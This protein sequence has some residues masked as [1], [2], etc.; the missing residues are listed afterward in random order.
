MNTK[1]ED[2]QDDP[3]ALDP[4]NNVRLLEPGWDWDQAE[5]EQPDSLPF[6]EPVAPAMELTASTVIHVGISAREDGVF[7]IT[8]RGHVFAEASLEQSGDPELMEAI[9]DMY[10]TRQ[11][12]LARKKEK[13]RL[14]KEITNL[15]QFLACEPGL[16][17]RKIKQAFP[18]G[19]AGRSVGIVLA[20]SGRHFLT[21]NGEINEKIFV[22]DGFGEEIVART[23]DIKKAEGDMIV[24]TNQHRELERKIADLRKALPLLRQKIQNFF[25]DLDFDELERKLGGVLIGTV[26]DNQDQPAILVQKEVNEELTE[27]PAKLKRQFIARHFGG[28]E[29]S[30]AAQDAL[31]IRQA[32][33]AATAAINAPKTAPELKADQGEAAQATVNAHGH[34]QKMPDPKLVPKND[35]CK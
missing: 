30:P 7:R 18:E 21:V 35:A 16:I 5:S 23:E 10:A 9:R 11:A 22:K 14:E 33:E 4:F 1:K 17:E 32:I 3:S 34:S 12:L 2:G 19:I 24:K 13:A 26:L 31:G 28:N 8:K 20:H 6:G 27:I 29:L 15:R 25:E